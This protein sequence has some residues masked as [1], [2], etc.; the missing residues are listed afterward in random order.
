LDKYLLRKS[1]FLLI[2]SSVKVKGAFSGDIGH[3]ESIEEILKV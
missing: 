2:D 1:L 3:F